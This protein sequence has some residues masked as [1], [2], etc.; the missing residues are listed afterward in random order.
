MCVCACAARTT[1]IGAQH[2]QR[3]LFL[4]EAMLTHSHSQTREQTN[5][6]THT[7]THTRASSCGTHTR[8]NT[9]SFIQL[10]SSKAAEQ[11]SAMRCE[12]RS[13][14]CLPKRTQLANCSTSYLP[15]FYPLITSSQHHTIHTRLPFSMQ[16]FAALLVAWFVC[17]FFGFG[18]CCWCVCCSRGFCWFSSS[19][20]RCGIAALVV[21]YAAAP[22][23]VFFSHSQSSTPSSAVFAQTI[24]KQSKRARELKATLDAR[25]STLTLSSLIVYKHTH[26]YSHTCIRMHSRTPA[27]TIL[28]SLFSFAAAVRSCCGC[29]QNRGLSPSSPSQRLPLPLPSPLICIVATALPVHRSDQC[30]S[31]CIPVCVSM[32]QVGH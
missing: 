9:L 4:N 27:R 11:A 3:K 28:I 7:H 21:G 6:N 20:S 19:P 30:V 12:R 8:I 2:K 17:C 32:W 22:L 10:T 14:R 31:L 18:C 15:T 1:R 5:A 26:I 25:L 16:L 13:L 23:C 29:E 24:V